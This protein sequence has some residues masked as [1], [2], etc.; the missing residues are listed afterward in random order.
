MI[1]AT[2][3]SNIHRIQ[4]VVNACHMYGRKLAVVGRSMVNVVNIAS[5]LGYLHVPSDLIIDLDEINR[6]P[7]NRVAVISTGSQGNRC[8]R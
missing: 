6:L 3:A 1:V 8:Q 4:Q 2:F 7:A 5:E